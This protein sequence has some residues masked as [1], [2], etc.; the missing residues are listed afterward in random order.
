MKGSLLIAKISGIKIR[1][2]WTFMILIAW[3]IISE[4]RRG[5]N[6]EEVL[7]TLGFIMAIFFTII[8]HE[9]GHALT[10]KQ[11]NFKTRD[12]TLLPIGGVARMD[13]LPNKPMQEFLV[14]IMGPMVNLAIAFI[15]FLTIDTSRDLTEITSDLHIN[16]SNF[17]FH[18]YTA[19][20]FLAL[21]N[22]IPAFPMDGGRVLRALLATSMKRA[23]ATRIAAIIGQ[24]IAVGFVFLGL[25]YNPVLLII[26]VFIF[27][28]AQAESTMETT[29]EVLKDIKVGDI[30]MH[31]YTELQ[32]KEPLSTAV[33][34]ILDSQERAFIIKDDGQLKGT[35]SKTEVIQGLAKF[36][37]AARIEQAMKTNVI[38][39]QEKDKLSDVIQQYSDGSETLMPVFSGDKLIG[40]LNLENIYEFVQIQSAMKQSRESIIG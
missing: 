10:A 36:G 39:L 5:S 25:L 2:H 13:N 8:L 21:F 27:I 6:A 20:I 17:L 40:V 29:R 31:S 23:K 28:G 22:L 32:A 3:I 11:F 9:L 34:M 35:L 14:A 18:L 4:A 16:G 19:N 33:A 38:P 15:L 7:W 24:I 12:I 1:I 37:N 26:G 30:L